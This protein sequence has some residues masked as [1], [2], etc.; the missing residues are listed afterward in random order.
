MFS[1][2]FL[3]CIFIGTFADDID[4]SEAKYIDLLPEHEKKEFLD[5]IAR[6]I[7][8][9]VQAKGGI[10]Q[11][12]GE[13]SDA[14][15]DAHSAYVTKLLREEGKNLRKSGK[16][17]EDKDSR[18]L[19][20]SKEKKLD[21]NEEDIIDLTLRE[22]KR[23]KRNKSRES[24]NEKEK[25]TKKAKNKSPENISVEISVKNKS[26]SKE[27]MSE[28]KTDSSEKIPVQVLYD[29][30]TKHEKTT[31][32]GLRLRKNT[33]KE[34]ESSATEISEFSPEEIK[35]SDS[36]ET[37]VESTTVR[38]EPSTE[39]TTV[40]TITKGS[41]KSETNGMT[42]RIYES[43]QDE[44]TSSDS[45]NKS[46]TD[47]NAKVSNESSST[48][49]S[50]ESSTPSET[51]LTDTKNAT[52]PLKD[53]TLNSTQVNKP[54]ELTP[55][56]RTNKEKE[57]KVID[58]KEDTSPTRKN[59]EVL[60]TTSKANIKEINNDL[61]E[62][63]KTKPD[64]TVLQKVKSTVTKGKPALRHGFFETS[65]ETQIEDTKLFHELKSRYDN[66]KV[67]HYEVYEVS[68]Y[69]IEI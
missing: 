47:T 25:V 57:S 2:F 11:A 67:K 30:I 66:D 63:M 33:S 35:S 58:S 48:E 59:Y 43:M 22:G 29:D 54:Q 61:D 49:E 27:V 18:S 53:K 44:D 31:K 62:N 6:R 36:V 34:N 56:L 40:Q 13:I 38:K 5:R 68:K 23:N 60:T 10:D 12:S 46:Q 3:T 39:A 64:S 65:A 7:F 55:V 16:N 21:P 4:S 37:K 14:K 1:I 9:E 50:K 15:L 32:A 69:N 52:E 17:K 26:K 45:D 42:E 19:D 51:I 24:S 28:I 8:E 20:H 41:E